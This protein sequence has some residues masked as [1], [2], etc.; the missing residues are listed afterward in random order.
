MF[1]VALRNALPKYGLDPTPLPT[2]TKN[3]FASLALVKVVNGT[4]RGLSTLRQS[5]DIIASIDNCGAQAF[6]D[7]TVQNLSVTLGVNVTTPLTDITAMVGI[8]ISVRAVVEI[9]E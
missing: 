5:G 3:L 4:I 6:L 9:V 8:N 7:V 2:L 1:E